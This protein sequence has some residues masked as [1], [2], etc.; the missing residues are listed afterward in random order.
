MF[1]FAYGGVMPLYAILVREYFGEK[2]MGSAFGAVSLTATVGM[3]LGA[4]IGR[5]ALR[6]GGQLRLD[7][8]R[9]VGHRPR[10]RRHRRELPAAARARRPRPHSGALGMTIQRMR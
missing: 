4:P 9:L 7:V 8:H 6:R 3:A 2:V 10:R 5:L 1:G